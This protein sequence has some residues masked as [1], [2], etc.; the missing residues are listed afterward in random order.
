MSRQ[1][2]AGVGAALWLIVAV[3]R[4]SM[5][6][7]TIVSFSPE[8]LDYVVQDEVTLL[9]GEWSVYR[10]TPVKRQNDLL[11]FLQT[12]GH[13]TPVPVR[14]GR[15]ELIRHRNPAW[16][17]GHGVLRSVFWNQ[18]HSVI[19]WT[20]KYPE[21]ARRYW[22]AGF[23]GLRSTDRK[24]ICFGQQVLLLGWRCQSLVEL[25]D[26]MTAIR[27]DVDELVR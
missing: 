25:E 18:Q 20:K 8:T 16:R 21:V 6:Q 3:L 27:Q 1:A 12:D 26:L 7:G 17:G 13:V 22:T 4:L 2:R 5:G 10:S 11:Q 15:M 14:T 23:Q 24:E 19:T 9:W